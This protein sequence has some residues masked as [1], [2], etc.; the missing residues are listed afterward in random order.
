MK[1]KPTVNLAVAVLLILIAV[2]GIV[3]V[4]TG[5]AYGASAWASSPPL[6]KSG[7]R[8]YHGRQYVTCKEAWGSHFHSWGV[9]HPGRSSASGPCGLLAST[10]RQYG[11]DNPGACTRY[12]SN[13]YGSWTRA[14]LHHRQMNWW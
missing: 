8:S 12:M 2:T 1:R 6:R 11:G 3:L 9:S 14:E 7:C 4:L 13:R 10:R 5:R